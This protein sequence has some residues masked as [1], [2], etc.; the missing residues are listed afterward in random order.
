[1]RL[2]KKKAIE[3]TIELW[4]WLAEMGN[5][6]K[7][8][9]PNWFEYDHIT[10]FCFLCEYQQRKNIYWNDSN[11]YCGYCPYFQRFGNDAYTV[12]VLFL[13]FGRVLDIIGNKHISSKN[14]LLGGG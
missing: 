10:F 9:W 1:M 4:E 7:S 8:E 2:T 5:E 14:P 11:D 3:L 6:C 12:H 13:E